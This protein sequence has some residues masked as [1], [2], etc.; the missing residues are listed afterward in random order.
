MFQ[1]AMSA[2]RKASPEKLLAKRE[3]DGT[4]EVEAKVEAGVEV[5]IERDVKMT[6]SATTE[7]GIHITSNG[8][9]VDE[10]MPMIGII[11]GD[12]TTA[13]II[14]NETFATMEEDEATAE[15]GS[16]WT[17]TETERMVE[18]EMTE[19]IH[20]VQLLH[21]RQHHLAHHHPRAKYSPS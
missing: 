4:A 8:N 16:E 6:E 21:H 11:E 5:E 17:D 7:I 20:E 13:E 1:A 15:T 10:M 19:L 3:K 18:K 2:N 14:G 9:L 12:E